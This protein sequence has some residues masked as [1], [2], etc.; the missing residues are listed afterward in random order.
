MP[1]TTIVLH[2]YAC[3]HI[4]TSDT[5]D[6]PSENPGYGP[7]T[8]CLTC[9][10]LHSACLRNMQFCLS[11]QYAIAI[12]LTL[13]FTQQA[14][15][16][17]ASARARL[18][19][20]KHEHNT[21]CTSGLSRLFTVCQCNKLCIAPKQESYVHCKP[22]QTPSLV[23]NLEWASLTLILLMPNSNNGLC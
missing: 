12:N 17:Y 14:T 8:D 23:P 6:S 2:A 13:G 1:Q 9:C 19:N 3:I 11:T 15:C 7:G 10:P 18:H 22:G 20:A 21:A 5:H 16:T 4:Y